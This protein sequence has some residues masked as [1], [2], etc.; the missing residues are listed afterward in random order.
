MGQLRNTGIHH[1][2]SPKSPLYFRY[3]WCYQSE[4]HVKVCQLSQN[5]FYPRIFETVRPPN[6]VI[7]DVISIGCILVKPNGVAPVFTLRLAESLV[8]A[9]VRMAYDAA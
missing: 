9:L 8:P 6:P 4:A 2:A 5:E 7:R 1:P 3:L